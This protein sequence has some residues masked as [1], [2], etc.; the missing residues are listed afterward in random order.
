MVCN[1]QLR[2]ALRGYGFGMQA[3]PVAATVRAA[4]DLLMEHLDVDAT[5]AATVLHDRAHEAD[6]DVHLVAQEILACANQC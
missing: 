4:I 5:Q 6:V 2:T 3:N 1:Q